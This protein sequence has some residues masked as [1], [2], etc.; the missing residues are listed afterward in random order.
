MSWITPLTSLIMM[1]FA[2]C[3]MANPI[4]VRNSPVSLPFAKQLKFT[5]SKGLVDRDRAR[6]KQL[7]SFSDAKQIDYLSADS[8]AIV[9]LDATNAASSY[10]TTVGIGSPATSCE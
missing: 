5:S 6:A 2:I 4:V 10:R 7:L 9:G 3:V 8:D 1:L